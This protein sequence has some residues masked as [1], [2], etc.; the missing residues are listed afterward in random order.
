MEINIF[1]ILI[2][3]IIIIEILIFLITL[4]VKKD[5]Q[6]ILTNKDEK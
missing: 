4:F 6:W 1:N 5:F 2:L 3:L